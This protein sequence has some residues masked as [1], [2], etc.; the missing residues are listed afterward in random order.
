[1]KIAIFDLKFH[2]RTNLKALWGKKIQQQA[3][4]PTQ[5][6][7]KKVLLSELHRTINLTVLM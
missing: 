2:R 6:G 3:Q 5:N 1:V 7:E 4:I